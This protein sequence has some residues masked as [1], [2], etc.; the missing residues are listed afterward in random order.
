MGLVLKWMN[1]LNSRPTNPSLQLG[2]LC[3]TFGTS[4]SNV[5]SVLS[6]DEYLVKT[7]TDGSLM[8]NKSLRPEI[9]H[10]VEEQCGTPDRTYFSEMRLG[11]TGCKYSQTGRPSPSHTSTLRRKRN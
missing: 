3:G 10:A 6:V 8:Q 11:E 1:N 7:C 9:L 2:I 5:L 4:C